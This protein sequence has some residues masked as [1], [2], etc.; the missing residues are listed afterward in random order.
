[1][2]PFQPVTQLIIFPAGIFSRSDNIFSAASI[3][4]AEL[5]SSR[6]LATV[7][8]RN[9][10]SFQFFCIYCRC[11]GYLHLPRFISPSV[12]AV[13]FITDLYHHRSGP[14]FYSVLRYRA[15]VAAGFI[16]SA[17]LDRQSLGLLNCVKYRAVSST[18]F[19][20]LVQH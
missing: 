7:Y 19:V 14:W 16:L 5:V 18:V 1:M 3:F 12:W 9:R 8:H 2:I 11:F 17:I 4:N 15:A 20:F 13:V 6:A 10:A